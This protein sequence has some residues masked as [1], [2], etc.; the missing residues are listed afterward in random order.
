MNP[1]KLNNTRNMSADGVIRASN[2][3]N[4]VDVQHKQQND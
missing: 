4:D 3:T 1:K 2:D